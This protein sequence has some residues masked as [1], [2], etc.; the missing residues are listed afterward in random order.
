[1]GRISA[2]DGIRCHRGWRLLAR[3]GPARFWRVEGDQ[4]RNL[5]LC[6]CAPRRTAVDVRGLI[7]VT[8]ATTV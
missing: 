8:E 4:G 5:S 3:A 1:M 6:K 7:L 2:V